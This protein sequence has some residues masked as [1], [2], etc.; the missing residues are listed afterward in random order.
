MF[1]DTRFAY[2][3]MRPPYLG[4][5]IPN[6]ETRSANPDARSMYPETRLAYPDT[7]IV[8]LETGTACLGTR[9]PFLDTRCSCLDTDIDFL[10][11]G[12]GFRP[13]NRDNPVFPVKRSKKWRIISPG[14]MRNFL[15]GPRIWSR[16]RFKT[17]PAGRFRSHKHSD[18]RKM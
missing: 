2:P 3:E 17:T 15:I 13:K 14:P 11:T 7:G 9:L 5:R 16:S 18:H 6:L 8:F 4:A 12:D 10:Y 1:L